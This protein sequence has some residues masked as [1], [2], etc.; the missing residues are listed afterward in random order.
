M[1]VYRSPPLSKRASL[2]S[3]CRHGWFSTAS[4]AKANNN[5]QDP[6]KDLDSSSL[7]PR[8]PQSFVKARFAPGE[9]DPERTNPLYRPRFT[10]NAK[11]ISADDFAA[12]PKAGTSVEFE[13]FSDAMMTPSWLSSRDQEQIFQMY[14]DLMV[15]SAPTNESVTSHEYA[16]RVVAQRF[17]I[18]ARRVAGVIRL[19]HN[20]QQ[21]RRAGIKLAD[22]VADYMDNAIQQEINEAYAS[23]NL[24]PPAQFVE[25]PI[26]V[27]SSAQSNK[28]YTAVDDLVDVESV[29]PQTQKRE[30]VEAQAFLDNYQYEIDL[31]P[32]RVTAPMDTDCKA[33][34]KR[35]KKLQK[36][37]VNQ[38]LQQQE[39]QTK[40]PARWKF[41]AQIVNT[42]E[43]KKQKAHK[44]PTS[45]TNNNPTNTIV[46]D[47]D[48]TIRAA[49]AAETA[50][51]DWKAARHVD[52]FIY[53]PV[54]RAWLQRQ[55]EPGMTDVWG[56]APPRVVAEEEG[57]GK[58]QED[59][60]T[61]TATTAEATTQTQADT[62]TT[63]QD[64]DDDTED[65]TS[66]SSSDEEESTNKEQGAET[67][68]DPPK[69]DSP[70]DDDTE[71]KPK[72]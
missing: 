19:Q 40:K 27:M 68:D 7:L 5:E 29:W 51:V 50:S 63:M 56:K 20:E 2:F 58:E 61:E 21:M 45:Y 41:M 6:G 60:E 66:S 26:G 44:T 52:K 16:I 9:W 64:Q 22:D 69:D 71:D 10:S 33:L 49:T 12:R 13:S 47:R 54:Q 17:R 31:E 14:C 67:H 3:R 42:R 59:N 30:D 53:G 36:E 4:N 32:E 46:V 43:L 28:F 8:A 37:S 57:K 39:Q 55:H 35:A 23:Q 11:I 15:S 70:D 62:T 25:D 65:G 18:T 48:G 24:R 38:P 72:E 1:Y 34:L